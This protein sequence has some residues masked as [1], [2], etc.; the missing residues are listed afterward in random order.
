MTNGERSRE[1]GGGEGAR[2]LVSVVVPVFNEQHT[3][4]RLVERLTAALE[5]AG[6]SFEVVFVNDGSRDRSAETLRAH[7]ARDP[8]LKC[9]SLSRNFGHQ[10]AVTCGLDH[11]TG[12]AVVVMDGDLQDPPEVLP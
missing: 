9:I 2:S 12:D 8:R 6:E 11:A 3:L 7:H 10:V 5:G 4:D 1:A